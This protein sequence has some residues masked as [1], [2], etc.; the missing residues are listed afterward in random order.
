MNTLLLI[1]DWLLRLFGAFF[2]FLLILSYAELKK[3]PVAD[4]EIDDDHTE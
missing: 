3:E 1:L 4:R 2:I